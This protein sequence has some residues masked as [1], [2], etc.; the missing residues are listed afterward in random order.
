MNMNM[1]LIKWLFI[2]FRI[3]HGHLS[4]VKCLFNIRVGVVQINFSQMTKECSYSII[5]VWIVHRRIKNQKSM[6]YDL[7]C[8]PF[9]IDV[10]V[11][12]YV[13]LEEEDTYITNRNKCLCL[14]LVDSDL[15][16]LEINNF[17][18]NKIGII[19][20]NVN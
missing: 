20:F 19:P 7:I 18:V 11:W 2:G 6:S 15:T 8:I 17:L 3:E 1:M 4:I 13:L 9:F 16:Y 5:V 14:Q 12:Y 10:Y